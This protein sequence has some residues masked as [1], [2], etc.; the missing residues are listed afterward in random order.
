M[1]HF[2]GSLLLFVALF[3]VL[4]CLKAQNK[5]DTIAPLR[6]SY[7]ET[8]FYYTSSILPKQTVY[9]QPYPHYYWHI[10]IPDSIGDKAYTIKYIEEEDL[11]GRI[12]RIE[13]Y[14]RTKEGDLKVDD[15]IDCCPFEY[16]YAGDNWSDHY[17]SWLHPTGIHKTV[18]AKGNIH[19]DFDKITLPADYKEAISKEDSARTDRKSVV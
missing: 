17:T 13:L 19:P 3:G 15:F 9:T 6:N 14:Q 7:I 1:F 8:H 2:A 16:L 11:W 12:E 4:S 5:A 18:L 10:A